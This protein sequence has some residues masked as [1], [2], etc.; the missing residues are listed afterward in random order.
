MGFLISAALQQITRR[1][2]CTLS[3]LSRAEGSVISVVFIQCCMVKY[4]WWILNFSMQCGK[5]NT[6]A[7]AISSMRHTFRHFLCFSK[8][9]R[10]CCPFEGFLFQFSHYLHN[11]TYTWL[12]CTKAAVMWTLTELAAG[13]QG[14]CVAIT[15]PR[16]WNLLQERCGCWQH[17]WQLFQASQTRRE[18]CFHLSCFYSLFH[19][20]LLTFFYGFYIIIKLI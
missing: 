12:N 16:D 11:T 17:F 6:T 14:Y 10:V 3:L 9:E 20:N 7:S 8:E 2:S 5:F 19:H 18:H 1:I 15:L 13:C 4:L